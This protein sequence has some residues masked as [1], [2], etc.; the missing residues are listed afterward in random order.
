M[1][2]TPNDPGTMV[3]AE[4]RDASA[5]AS[6]SP[7]W[8]D[9]RAPRWKTL[10]KRYDNSIKRCYVCT[11][12]GHEYSCYSQWQIGGHCGLWGGGDPPGMPPHATSIW[13]GWNDWIFFSSVATAFNRYG[14]TLNTLVQIT[15]RDRMIVVSWLK[16]LAS[17]NQ[18]RGQF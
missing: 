6:S 7:V 4:R 17:W 15:H 14:G 11:M 2:V 12:R 5:I 8:N 9:N 3:Q 13:N 10:K 18:F 16:F 1:L